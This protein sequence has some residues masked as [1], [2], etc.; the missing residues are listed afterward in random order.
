MNLPIVHL[1]KSI[2]ILVILSFTI[3]KL[4]HSFEPLRT[5]KQNTDT[6]WAN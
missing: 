6:T 3:S 2:L 5:Y 1:K 4:V